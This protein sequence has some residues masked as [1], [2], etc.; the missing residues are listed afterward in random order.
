M[1]IKLEG[2]SETLFITLY[3]RGKDAMSKKPILND[4]KSLEIM[5]QI[6]YDF[7]KFKK[8]KASY[9]GTL[10]RIC[11]MDRQVKKFISEDPNCNIISVGC[12]LDTRFERVD[13]GKIK[14]YNLDFPDVISARDFFFEKN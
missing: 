9:H 7:E 13:N 12:G 11:V 1:K 5:R 8:S 10:A 4:L 3:I 14:W 2:V 6:D